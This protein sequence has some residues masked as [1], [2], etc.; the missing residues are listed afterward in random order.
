VTVSEGCADNGES[1]GLP[2]TQPTNPAIKARRDGDR[3]F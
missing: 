1:T 2:L 3:R